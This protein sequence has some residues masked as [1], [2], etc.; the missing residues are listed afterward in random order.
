M[1]VE[2]AYAGR[3]LFIGG[4][5]AGG[6]PPAPAVET[7]PAAPTGGVGHA[8]TDIADAPQANLPRSAIPIAHAGLN[9]DAATV[10]TAEPGGAIVSS[11]TFELGGIAAGNGDRE[12]Q[13]K[14]PEAPQGTFS[15]PFS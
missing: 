9:G 3:A 4:A 15:R 7:D 10:Q 1:G 13:P 12:Q 14:R 5:I 8:L 6:T 2:I 11:L